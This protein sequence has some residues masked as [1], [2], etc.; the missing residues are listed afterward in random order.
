MF[1]LLITPKPVV[2]ESLYGYLYRLAHANGLAGLEVI[3]MHRSCVAAGQA[4]WVQ[5]HSS[6]SWLL[7]VEELVH[8][9]TD[10]IKV[11]SL[12]HRKCCS[13]CLEESQHW[14]ALWDLTL[15]TCCPVHK[16][17]LQDHCSVCGAQFKPGVMETFECTEC[18]TSLSFGANPI[19]AD[20]MALWVTCEFERRLRHRPTNS[21]PL[22][23]LTINEFHELAKRFGVRESHS[24]L[25]KPL[26]L[27]GAGALAAAI[28]L[29][30]AAGQILKDWPHGFWAFLDKLAITRQAVPGWKLR[31][32]FGQT[33]KDIH[34]G[35][36]GAAFQF[37]RNAFGRYVESRWEGPLARRN[38]YLCSDTITSH[39]W[40][41]IQAAAKK[42]NVPPALLHRMV[43]NGE[44]SH[45]EM[46]YPSGRI[47]L[48]VDYSELTMCAEQLKHA[49]SLEEAADCLSI[50]KPRVRQLLG[51][52]LLR[53]LGGKPSPGEQW[54][55]DGSSLSHLGTALPCPPITDGL[56]SIT[57]LAKLELP[58]KGSFV[59]LIAS[60]QGG[61]I[62]AYVVNPD[63]DIALGKWLVP[64][65][66]ITS[67]YS[68]DPNLSVV[69]AAFLLGV[70][71]E[72]AYALIRS[73]LLTSYPIRSGRRTAKCVPQEA[74]R[75]FN[76]SFVLGPELARINKTSLK[77]IPS[78][79]REHG[80]L[81]VAGPGVVGAN[82]RQYV[83]P[84]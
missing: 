77:S 23:H 25:D 56:V 2:D 6:V 82:C 22:S 18:G 8:P 5:I 84:R 15:A 14:R 27:A 4:E 41:S 76:Q 79:M 61:E 1:G 33:Y 70:K 38:R 80:V 46:N 58:T 31:S 64:R 32:V 35:L 11:W 3:A 47:G 42:V 43:A 74:I 24:V 7:S 48:V 28:P 45:R 19:R 34:S 75:D 81:P 62:T 50:T 66:R 57:Q 51:A 67:I 59:E 78:I 73:G 39:R 26:K 69:E 55:I 13:Q 37:V 83:W 30:T 36:K 49:V 16:N 65:C 54:W 71:Q 10:A 17:S 20:S 29:A 53:P 52:G 68:S 9:A 44:L 21:D 63:D 12:Q 60:I 40:V 72:V